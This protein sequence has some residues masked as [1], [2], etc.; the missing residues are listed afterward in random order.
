MDLRAFKGEA[1]R[2]GVEAVV[3]DPPP[4][5][6]QAPIDDPAAY[7]VYATLLADHE[8]VRMGAKT[9]VIRQE[10]TNP[11]DRACLPSGEAMETD[12]R[13]VL[14]AYNAANAAVHSVLGGDRL[15]RP[16]TVVSAARIEAVFKDS[17][18]G[19]VWDAFHRRYPDARG[20]VEVSAVGFDA[21][22]R[23]A[24][25]Y[26]AHHCGLLCGGGQVY[27]LEKVDGTWRKVDPPGLQRCYW[28]S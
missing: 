26:L 1:G 11:T 2:S 18:Q 12:W 4:S 6:S 22:R 13:P 7:A 25:V 8:L 5:S 17:V 14:E 20:Y 15:G 19:A 27:L 3:K 23:R 21:E 16:Y 28:V 10:T 9:L 24:M